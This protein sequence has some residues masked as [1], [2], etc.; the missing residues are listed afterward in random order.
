VLALPL[1]DNVGDIG[2]A[3]AEDE[4]Q[5]SNL[6][7]LLVGLGDHARVGHD[8]DII[9]QLVGG[10]E[11]LDHRQHRLGLGHV[12]LERADHQREARL[13]GE[14]ANGDLRVQAAFLGE[15]ALT[16]P[17]PGVGLEVQRAD[18][19]EHQAHE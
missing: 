12:P 19:V 15:S 10:H 9:R 4:R 6:D 7:R 1:A 8:R 18:V 11:R 5:P 2:D 13:V 3:H 16:E 17:V 14:Q